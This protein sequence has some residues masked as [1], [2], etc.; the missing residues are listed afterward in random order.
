MTATPTPARRQPSSAKPVR[1][2]GDLFFSSASIG[3]ATIILLT[4]AGVAVFLLIEALPALTAPA[5]EVS[6]GAGFAGYVWPLVVGTV[7]ASLVAMVLATPVAVGIALFVSHYAPRRLGQSIG[8]VIDLLAAVPSV[9]FGMWGMSVFAPRLVPLYE[10]LEQNLGFIPLFADASTSG[11]T[12]MTASI[13]LAVMILPIITAVSREVFLQTPSLHEE[14]ALALGATK[15]EMIRTAV[16]PFGMPGV[17][18]GTMLGL[19]RALG[20]T[21]AVAII[22]SPGIFTWNLIGSGN[23]TIPAEIALNFPEAA[24]LR[25]SELIAAG[26]VLFVIT[27]AVNLFARWI[28]DRRAEFS[29][30]N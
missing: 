9:V 11:R 6:G 28:V 26:L 29:G 5:D 21:M 12:L 8:F 27:L 13:V 1:R 19:G 4:L 7:V 16:L 30:A 23:N 18:G 20:E 2:P 17:I 24:G 3:S 14:A 25:L 22:L 15:W 10:W